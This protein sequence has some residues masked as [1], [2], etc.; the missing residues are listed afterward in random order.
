MNP[1]RPKQPRLRLDP[2]SYDN[3]GS[4]CCAAMAGDANPAARCR[5]LRFTTKNSVANRAK[6]QRRI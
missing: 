1:I 4:R 3:S 2:A 6:I 5:I